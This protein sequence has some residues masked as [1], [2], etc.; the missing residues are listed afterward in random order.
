MRVLSTV[1]VAVLIAGLSAPADVYALSSA[2]DVPVSSMTA[3]PKVVKMG[4]RNDYN[5]PVEVKVGD[6]TM[7]LAAGKTV[8]LKLPVGTPIVLNTA[9]EKHQIGEVLAQASNS[10]QDMTLIIR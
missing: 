6:Q 7:S 10:M 5:Q 8:Q 9:T 2:A 1:A 3:K 4:L